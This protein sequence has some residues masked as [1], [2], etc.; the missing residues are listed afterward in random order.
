MVKKRLIFASVALIT[1]TGCASTITAVADRPVSSDKFVFA[2]DSNKTQKISGDRR[3]ARVYQ[4]IPWE[5]DGEG[6][7]L[8]DKSGQ[9]VKRYPWYMC[10]E[11]HADA[12]SSKGA[13]SAFAIAD[14]GSMSDAVTCAL[15][16][17][18]QRTQAADIVRRLPY[19]ACEAYLNSPMDTTDQEHYQKRIDQIIKGSLEFL[20]LNLEKP[21]TSQS[22]T[23]SA[24][25]IAPPPPVIQKSDKAIKDAEAMKK[26]LDQE[27]ADRTAKKASL[28]KE[29]EE[30]AAKLPTA[31]PG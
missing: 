24:A 10:I 28:D 16:Q 6:H 11:P 3:F 31:P 14:K 8:Q 15:L 12:I 1:L 4:G 27:I 9:P 29:I 20:T 22:S 25:P 2:K 30:R 21:T 26:K 5:S 17:T 7:I 19:V 23:S 13:S 18:F